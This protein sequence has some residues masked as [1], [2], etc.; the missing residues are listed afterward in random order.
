MGAR[1]G[2]TI[3]QTAL[4][5]ATQAF[6]LAEARFEAG[7]V[8]RLDLATAE[9]AR[10][11]AEIALIQAQNL[12]DTERVRLMQQIG[13]ELN[14]DVELTT[15]FEVFEP[16]WTA[17]EL[18]SRAMQAHPQLVA[19]RKAESAANAS[20][21]S[22]WSQYL[23]TLNLGGTLLSGNVSRQGD[24][25]YVIAQA[26][27]RADNQ[28]DNCE[29]NNALNAR[30][31]SPLPGWPKDCSTPTPWGRRPLTL[32]TC[33]R[34]ISRRAPCHCTCRFRTPSSMG[35]SGSGPCRRPVRP[36]TTPSMRAG[37]KSC[38]GGQ[39]SRTTC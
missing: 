27:N 9:V 5:A 2:V 22:S 19:A 34:S 26:R 1:D 4:D 17:E 18:M 23:P 3:A 13:V 33:F 16:R 35:S 15:S 28:V 24:D 7:A 20:A 38:S 10:G 30:L 6:R 25:A 37:P 11:R 31:T 12:H 39:T 29:G 36:R 21:K 14:A 32:T 8:T